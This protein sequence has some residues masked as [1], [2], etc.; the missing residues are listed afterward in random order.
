MGNS[1]VIRAEASYALNFLVYLQNIFLNQNNYE[2]VYHF[3]YIL[4]KHL[5]F[6]ENFE[7]QFK[8]L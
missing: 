3:P 5:A 4:T 6:E 8:N 2:E 7:V 1:L